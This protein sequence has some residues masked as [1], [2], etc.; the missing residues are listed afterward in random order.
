MKSEA[1]SAEPASPTLSA[2]GTKEE[3][4]G[5]GE[6]AN[7]AHSDTSRSAHQG[8]PPRGGRN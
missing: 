2:V 6:H 4:G 3:A 5:W 8:I 7:S 1:L